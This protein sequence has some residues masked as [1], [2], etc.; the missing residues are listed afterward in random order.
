MNLPSMKFYTAAF[1]TVLFAVCL[2]SGVTLLEPVT[3]VHVSSAIKTSGKAGEPDAAY[4]RI[5]QLL[6]V[7]LKNGDLG[8]AAF[9][10]QQIGDI[11]FA[12]GAMSQ[13]LSY[14]HKA[15]ACFRKGT[16]P[17]L[18]GVNLNRMGRIYFKNK[19]NEAALTRFRGALVLFK[20]R[21]YHPGMAESYGYIGQV[22]EQKEVYDSSHFYQELALAEF[23]SLH[24]KAQVAYTYA[25]IGSIYEDQGKFDAALKYFLLV[26]KM[27]RQEP[28]RVELAAVLNN[29]GDTYRKIGSYRQAL[30]YSKKAEVLSARLFDNRQLSSAHR[31]LA[32]TFA[33]LGRFD[34]AYYYS[35]K[36]R[37]AYSKSYNTDSEKKLN[38]IQTIFDIQSKDS[39][40]QQLESRNRVSQILAGALLII[41]ILVLFLG[42]SLFSRQR[43]I[44]QNSKALFETRQKSME[45]ALH[46]KHLQQEALKAELELRSKELTGITL[47]MIK[48][49]EVLEA[50]RNKLASM[51]KDDKR[52]QRKELKLLLEGIHFNSNE[53]KSWQDFRVVFEYVHK[54]FFEKLMKH[55]GSLTTTDL[56]FL[57]LLKMNLNS[58]DMATMLTVSQTSLRTTRYRLRKKLR[59][60][61]DASL[62]QFVHHL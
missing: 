11:L 58:A 52:D 25:H 40:I 28:A 60:P 45:L 27:Y 33:Q 42:I 36:S 54:D 35:E 49:N 19:R 56:R 9:C 61:E 5:R 6:E 44:I 22:Y 17:V 8:Q 2:V 39:E 41:S 24:D 4:L 13:A 14:Y 57:A 51:V 59:L 21:G 32:K 43:L 16:N 7:S 30:I 48:K 12:E 62:Q 37:L 26:E 15:D 53:D 10:Y 38:L 3:M 50:L 29:I 23:R 31:D 18:L 55:S 1:K 46:N 34:S 20:S 47:H